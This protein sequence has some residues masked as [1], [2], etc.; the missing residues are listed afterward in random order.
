MKPITE[1]NIESFSIKTLQ[2]IGWGYRHGLA[3]A[4]GTEQAERENA[5]KD[6]I[7]QKNKSCNEQEGCSK[8]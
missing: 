8:N 6:L 4:P 1:N 7:L 5:I 3:T 2:N